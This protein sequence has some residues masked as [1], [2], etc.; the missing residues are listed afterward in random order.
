[1]Y[2]N[3]QR[4]LHKDEMRKTECPERRNILL[5]SHEGDSEGPEDNGLEC[6]GQE[7]ELNYR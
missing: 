1:M 3:G 5:R 4:K 7:R 2:Q 6:T